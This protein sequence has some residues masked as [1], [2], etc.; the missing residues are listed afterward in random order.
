M[1]TAQNT[2]Q[3]LTRLYQGW[4]AAD[5]QEAA[6]QERKSKRDA[7]PKVNF[8]SHIVEIIVTVRARHVLCGEIGL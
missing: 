8:G 3:R 5:V 4:V 2:T 7:L 6:T 1:K